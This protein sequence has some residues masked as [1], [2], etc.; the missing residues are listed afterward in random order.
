MRKQE[1]EILLS[2]K[3]FKRMFGVTE[4]TAERIVPLGR[5]WKYWK[6]H[7]RDSIH[8]EGNRRKEF[9]LRTQVSDAGNGQRPAA[10]NFAVFTGIP[11]D[12]TY[13]V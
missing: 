12:G 7:I 3:E 6:R 8:T 13:R 2:G 4:A 10:Y 9:A 5:C 11:D 1:Q